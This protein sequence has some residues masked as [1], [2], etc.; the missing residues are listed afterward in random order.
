MKNRKTPRSVTANSDSIH[1]PDESDAGD[2]FTHDI[3]EECLYKKSQVCV[4]RA[5][6]RAIGHIDSSPL[7]ET[8]KQMCV[9]EMNPTEWIEY[10]AQFAK[11]CFTY[12][13]HFYKMVLVE[14]LGECS[15]SIQTAHHDQIA[16]CANDIFQS[17]SPMQ[18]QVIIQNLKKLE[19]FHSDTI[20]SIII[21]GNILKG[22]MTEENILEDICESLSH[23]IQECTKIKNH[24][25]DKASSNLNNTGNVSVSYMAKFTLGGLGLV[26]LGLIV[27]YIGYQ[28]MLRRELEGQVNDKVNDALSK[29]YM[30][31]KEEG[32]GYS[33]AS[34]EKSEKKEQGSGI[35]AKIAAEECDYGIEV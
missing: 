4:S 21:N 35:K 2:G 24:K 15:K 26:C 3:S 25:L 8:I 11:K 30:T 1:K 32:A 12:D 31:E 33:G 5:D 29:Y 34:F 14:S 22:E 9:Y 18:Q 27:F 13:P 6:G 23:D 16:D 17:D 10:V 7:L 19:Q 28:F 20:P